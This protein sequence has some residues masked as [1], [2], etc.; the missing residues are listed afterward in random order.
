MSDD[1]FLDVVTRAQHSDRIRHVQREPARH[2]Y[3]NSWPDWVA[4][5]VRTALST[6]GIDQLW[7]HQRQ[8]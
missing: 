2:G 6:T 1:P 8:A 7:E 3:T 4:D 5:P